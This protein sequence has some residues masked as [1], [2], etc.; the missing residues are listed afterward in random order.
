MTEHQAIRTAS[1][2]P[3]IGPYSQ[4]IRWDRLIFTSSVS[5]SSPLHGGDASPDD[6]AS[7]ARNALENL[8]QIL[9]A[10]GSSLDHVLKVTLYLRTM[11]DFAAVNAVYAQFFTA[12]PRPARSLVAV[13][14][15]RGPVSFDAIAYVPE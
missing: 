5:T 11:D 13:A 8:R 12:E 3:P 1:A 4:G 14:G 7:A 2:A 6:V 15:A 10:G 9:Q